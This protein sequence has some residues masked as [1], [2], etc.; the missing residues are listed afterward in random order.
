MDVLGA[1]EQSPA[2]IAW[3]EN[4]GNETSMRYAID[5]SLQV[6]VNQSTLHI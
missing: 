4:D 5:A 2:K 3:Y 6:V 1:S